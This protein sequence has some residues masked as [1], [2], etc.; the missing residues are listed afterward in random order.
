M[1]GVHPYTT[2]G[3]ARTLQ[4]VGHPMYVPAWDSHMIV[5]V[6]D[7]NSLDATGPYPI[8]FLALGSDVCEGLRQLRQARM[9]SVVLVTDGLLGLG[10]K[11]LRQGFSHVSPFK[12]HYVVDPTVGPYQATEHHKYEIRRAANRGIAVRVVR[13]IDVLDD[14]TDMYDQLIARHQ[15]SGAQRFSRTSFEAL[16]HCEGL[17]AVAAF[18]GD[19]LVGCHLW[20]EYEGFVWS[21]LAA[22]SEAGYKNGA[23][24][25]LYDYSI[26]MF[27]NSVIDLGGAAGLEDAPSDG[28]ALFKAGFS[29]RRQLTYLCGAVLDAERYSALCNER[30]AAGDY[31]PLYR[32]ARAPQRYPAN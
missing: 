6:V 25:A 9:V 4:H 5:R 15:I 10:E 12:T 11:E 17:T 19:S 23:S 32:T 22:T 7:E 18:L 26:R 20:F 8:A 31:F 27:S 14:W 13:L 2:L 29:N 21:H 3:Y 16:A 24:Y 1:K 28:L 30:G